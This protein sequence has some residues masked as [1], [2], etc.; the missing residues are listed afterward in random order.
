MEGTPSLFQF[1]GKRNVMAVSTGA[2][3]GSLLPALAGSSPLMAFAVVLG[4]VVAGAAMCWPF[5]SVV[6][7]AAVIPLERVGR[8]TNDN[9]AV[10]FS[11]MRVLGLLGLAAL[12]LHALLGKRRLRIAT[13]VVLYAVYI[14][15]C[16]LTLTYTSDFIR[17]FKWCS[18]MVGN[19]LF[20]FFIANA[21]RS[22]RQIRWPI[23]LWLAT[24]LVIG[25]FTMYQWHSGKAVIQDDRFQNSGYRTTDDRFSTVIID[26]SEFDSIGPVKRVLGST[27][28]PAVYAINIILTLP[29]YVFL[30][31]T[32][33][34]WWM[35]MFCLAGLGVGVYNILLTNTRA[36]IVALAFTLLLIWMSPLVRHKIAILIAGLILCGTCAP[37][38]PTAMY[39]RVLSVGNYSAKRSAAIQIRLEYWKAGV[40]MFRDHWLLGVGSGNQAELPRR[41]SN[42]RMP[43]NTSIHNEFIESLLETGI[44]GYPV[45]VGFMVV[46]FRRCMRVTRRARVAH[47]GELY[48]FGVA[49]II[50]FVVVLAYGLQCDVFH[51]TLKGWWLLM[52]L[53][54]GVYDMRPGLAA[55]VAA[56]PTPSATGGPEGLP[57]WA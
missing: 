54:V 20:L 57:A 4:L 22:S 44:V 16:L 48:L 30:W 38:L 50:A 1:A 19:L 5:L 49:T 7:A 23:V 24:T 21:I 45:I 3:A 32:T 33:R 52:G 9:S 13:P 37:F 46:L 15:I 2:V 25:G 27:S 47:D 35:R 14:G 10:T 26:Y 42:M 8:F 51:F 56:E 43:P 29:F 41:L 53:M 39:K 34:S 18:T 40:D 12:L 55:A 31:A 17:G 28:H 6:L 11:I 36:G